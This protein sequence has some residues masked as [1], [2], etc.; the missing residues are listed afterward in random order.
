MTADR[1]GAVVRSAAPRSSVLHCR[2]ASGGGQRHIRADGIGI[3]FSVL[4][5]VL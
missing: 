2:A 1:A 3:K 4:I 5:Y